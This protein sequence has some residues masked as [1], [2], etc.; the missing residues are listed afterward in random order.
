MQVRTLCDWYNPTK[1]RAL[2]TM[3]CSLL[4]GQMHA[5][6]LLTRFVACTH[7]D[8]HAVLL[9]RSPVQLIACLMPHD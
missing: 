1:Q 9:S 4:A 6:Q 7:D 5:L 2:R 3:S 8:E